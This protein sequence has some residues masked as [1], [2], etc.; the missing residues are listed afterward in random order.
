MVPL[1]ELNIS[2]YYITLTVQILN[3]NEDKTKNHRKTRTV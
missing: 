1:S 3:L 2:A